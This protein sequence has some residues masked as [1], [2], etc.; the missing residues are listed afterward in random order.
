MVDAL[1]TPVG[2]FILF[3]SIIGAVVALILGIVY[4]IKNSIIKNL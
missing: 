4:A 3:L 1:R 2:Q